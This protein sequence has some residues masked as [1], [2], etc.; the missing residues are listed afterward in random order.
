VQ[1][2]PGKRK[3]THASLDARAPLRRSEDLIVETVEDE[4]LVYDRVNQRAHC[5]SAT[6]ARVWK[7]CDGSNDLT[8]ISAHL[9]LPLELVRE[10]VEELAASELLDQGLELVTVG[11]G[12]GNGRAI[13][14][15]ELAAR[16]AKV[17]AA[18][19]SVPLIVSLAVPTPAAAAS[20][21]LAQCL[22]YTDGDCGTNSVCNTIAGCC[23]CCNFVSGQCKICTPFGSCPTTGNCPSGCPP[24]CTGSRTSCS[25]G[26]IGTAPPTTQGCCGPGGAPSGGGAAGCGC[27][28]GP[29]GALTN[30][31]GVTPGGPGGGPGCCDT[32]VGAAGAHPGCG[33]GSTT[34]TCVPCCNGFA[35]STASAGG[36]CSDLTT[37]GSC[38]P[39]TPP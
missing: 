32:S 37:R 31:S 34:S 33:P 2:A 1:W 23:C 16:S 15:R 29:S 24:T 35:I 26:A 30:P 21:T 20:P 25:A 18:A 39:G 38:L 12:N 27:V 19:A 10:A 6:A 3:H 11:S 7:A 9:S 22:A 36:C 13:T 8:A 4:L 17:G 14:R 28:F 5:L